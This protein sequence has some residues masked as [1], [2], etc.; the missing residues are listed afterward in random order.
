VNY[1]PTSLVRTILSSAVNYAGLLV[2]AFVMFPVLL[3]GLGAERYG[4]WALIADFTGYY[5]YCDFGIRFA[6]PYHIAMYLTRGQTQELNECASTAFWSVCFLGAALAL[7]GLGLASWLPFLFHIEGLEAKEAQQAIALMG[8]AAGISLPI[9]TLNSML[10]GALRLDK[11]NIINI[12][13]RLG[14]SAA[15]LISIRAGGGLV[16][17]SLI[18]L[19]TRLASLPWIHRSVHKAIPTLSLAI[20]HWR[21]RHARQLA[22]YGLPSILIAGGWLIG[23][24]TD[25]AIIGRYASLSLVPLYAIPRSLMEYANAG[26]RAI[27]GSYIT[28]LTNLHVRGD[29]PGILRLFQTGARL[30]GLAIALFCAGIIPFG[31][32][33]LTLWQGTAFV[34][35]PWKNQGVVVLSIL[36][37]AFVPQMAQNMASQLLFS[38]K[39]LAFMVWTSILDGVCKAA[40]GFALVKPWGLAGVAFANLATTF[41]FQGVAMAIYVFRGF[42]IPVHEYVRDSISR[43]ALAGLGAGLTGSLLTAVHPPQSW[44]S[45][46]LEVA[47]TVASGLVVA[48]SLALTRDERAQLP[49]WIRRPA[50]VRGLQ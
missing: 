14:G 21:W 6:V 48:Y 45:L 32:P 28:H 47:L 1:R 39:R 24:R 7:T 25:L 49:T 17:L 5:A 9:E 30:S 35:G 27:T 36:V 31:R 22:G 15:M 26:V 3:R 33:F 10:T 4:L 20:G 43:P 18:Q 11:V 13:L 23:G 42:D 19:S 38:T 50:W 2:I 12:V 40:L 41:V 8:I 34:S 46:I 37:I 29:T 16:A 44:V